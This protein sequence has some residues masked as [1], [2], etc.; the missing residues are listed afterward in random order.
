MV[1]F[2]TGLSKIG[3]YLEVFGVVLSV[4]FIV[5]K[6]LFERHIRKITPEGEDPRV[7]FSYERIV[8]N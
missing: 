1:S 2:L 3:G 4:S 6:M 7:F 5:Q 8:D